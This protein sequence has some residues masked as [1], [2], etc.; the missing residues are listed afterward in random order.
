MTA[1]SVD[2]E[3]IRLGEET[4]RTS[5]RRRMTPIPGMIAMAVL[6]RR[7][8]QPHLRLS[9]DHQ[10]GI[11]GQSHL[12]RRGAGAIS[13]AGIANRA[14]WAMGAIR[15]LVRTLHHGRQSRTM[16]AGAGTRTRITAASTPFR[17]WR[18]IRPG[19]PWAP[20]AVGAARGE[21][22]LGPQLAVLLGRTGD[23]QVL[24]WRGATRPRCIPR[25]DPRLGE[26]DEVSSTRDPMRPVQSHLAGLP[27][28]ID[29]VRDITGRLPL[30]RL[31]ALPELQP[32]CI[33]TG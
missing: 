12:H 19:L 8:S 17:Q 27:I 9:S 33:L 5:N 18:T 32:A 24:K 23:S 29:L 11:A 25:P 22:R 6:T 28:T 16:A 13:E 7:C 26:G 31:V 4:V 1:E 30:R 20:R 14:G 2:R 15:R 10:R 21:W 3:R